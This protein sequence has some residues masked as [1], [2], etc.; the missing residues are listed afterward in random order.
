MIRIGDTDYT[1]TFPA[2]VDTYLDGINNRGEVVGLYMNPNSGEGIFEGQLLI[3]PEPSSAFLCALFFVG[4]SI[5]S[6]CRGSK[7]LRRSV[8]GVNGTEK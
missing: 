4:G 6:V 5:L 1:Y 2:A 7:L 8:H 3:T